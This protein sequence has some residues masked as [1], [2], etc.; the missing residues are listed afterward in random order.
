[1]ISDDEE[2]PTLEPQI[3][4]FQA[5]QTILP[6]S[7]SQSLTPL[8]V[9]KGLD[10]TVDDTGVPPSKKIVLSLPLKN[11]CQMSIQDSDNKITLQEPKQHTSFTEDNHQE[12]Q[13]QTN[14]SKDSQKESNDCN[15]CEH[16][17]KD[18]VV[19]ATD[20]ELISDNSSKTID[21]VVSVSNDNKDI[22]DVM[23]SNPTKVPNKR[24][25][26]RSSKHVKKVDTI[27]NNIPT[28]TGPKIDSEK[29]TD[30]NFCQQKKRKIDKISNKEMS[31]D[32][33]RKSNDARAFCQQ[34]NTVQQKIKTNLLNKKEPT[35]IKE[36]SSMKTP[37]VTMDNRSNSRMDTSKDQINKDPNLTLK[38]S[39]KDD[40]KS[41]I[42]LSA[43][44]PRMNGDP[45]TRSPLQNSYDDYMRR[46]E[47]S[48]SSTSWYV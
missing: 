37:I 40:K 17:H 39:T 34:D 16:E 48:H 9:T 27:L 24:K 20:P 26:K 14:F 35:S 18:D 15:H 11:V 32:C 31:K 45:R 30:N 44:V 28:V 36:E 23:D 10:S 46:L 38:I 42:N 12:P 4:G 33:N 6:A 21:S 22:K 3:I 29:D 41:L 43:T 13:Q 2:P 25:R 1:M 19:N 47:A 5:E 7:P 8:H